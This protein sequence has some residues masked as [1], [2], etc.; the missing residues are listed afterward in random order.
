MRVR[1]QKRIPRLLRGDRKAIITEID[2]SR[3][4]CHDHL[5]MNA[6]YTY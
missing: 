6:D 3:S 2:R 4:R 1:G 5:I